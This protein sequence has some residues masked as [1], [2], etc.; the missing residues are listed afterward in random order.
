M[1]RWNWKLANKRSELRLETI[2]G[3]LDTVNWVRSSQTITRLPSSLSCPH[4][5]RHRV[6]EGVDPTAN[7]LHIENQNVDILK[8]CLG[9]L[10][11]FAVKRIDWQAGLAIRGMIS[12]DHV[13]LNVA[14]NAVLGSEQ[15]LQI[16]S[17][18]LMKEIGHVLVF[19]IDGCLIADKSDYAHLTRDQLVL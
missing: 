17:R 16:L 15:R 11:S 2:T 9:R 8:H 14:P 10:A 5:I 19:V 12:L 18:L 13:V 4:A 1:T 3:H 7:V 6:D